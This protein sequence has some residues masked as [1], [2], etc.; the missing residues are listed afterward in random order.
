MHSTETGT[1]G[2]LRLEIL[3]INGELFYGAF[4]GANGGK[5]YTLGN[6]SSIVFS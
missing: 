1:N 2:G 3:F 6:F 4:A 5:F